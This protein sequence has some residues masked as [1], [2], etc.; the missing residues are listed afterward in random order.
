[1]RDQRR[2]GDGGAIRKPGRLDVTWQF[3]GRA[4]QLLLGEKKNIGLNKTRRLSPNHHIR[5]E[6]K[7]KG[8]K[9]SAEVDENYRDH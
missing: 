8:K 6:R 2:G 3:K 7:M 4:R 1:M 5:N 9:I